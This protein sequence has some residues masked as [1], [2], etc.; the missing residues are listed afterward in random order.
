MKKINKKSMRVGDLI[1]AE[2]KKENVK[3]QT[4]VIEVYGKGGIY[5]V[6]I[7]EIGGRGKKDVIDWWGLTSKL[8]KEIG[9]I[10]KRDYNMDDMGWK[11]FDLF[12]LNKKEVLEFTKI[13]I[14]KNL[15]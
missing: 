5:I 13:Q 11:R 6:K 9:V 8:S 2:L 4:G 10:G 12:R 15:E 1:Y 14:L 7:I 3:W